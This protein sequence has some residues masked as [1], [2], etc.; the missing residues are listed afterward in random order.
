MHFCER[1]R[2]LLD[3]ECLSAF[4]KQFQNPLMLV[5]YVRTSTADDDAFQGALLRNAGC[6][7]IYTDRTMGPRLPQLRRAVSALGSG[8]VL[9]VRKLDRL[10]HGIGDVIGLLRQIEARQ[11]HLRS[12]EDA[13]DTTARSGAL[14]FRLASAIADADRQHRGARARDG[15]KAAKERG[16]PLGRPPKLSAKQVRL[17]DARV[18][19]GEALA[20]VARSFGVS[21]LTLRRAFHARAADVHGGDARPLPSRRSA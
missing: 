15:M 3:L 7:V 4:K 6:Q 1:C 16:Q 11:A 10:G 12:L 19:D 14:I 5:G 8:D 20:D 18:A 2:R 13:L 9:V 17:A 21:A